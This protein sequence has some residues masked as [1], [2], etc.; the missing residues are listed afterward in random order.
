MFASL[1]SR[2]PAPL[3]RALAYAKAFAFL[4]EPPPALPRIRSE[5]RRPVVAPGPHPAHACPADRR[6]RTPG[7][8]PAVPLTLQ[9]RACGQHA[10][11]ARRHGAVPRP[12]QP[13]RTPTNGRPA[14]TSASRDDRRSAIAGGFLHR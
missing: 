5:P 8:R 11:P 1:I 4:E 13:C 9:L 14:T 3:R 6:R 2:L 12:K 10:T 7:G